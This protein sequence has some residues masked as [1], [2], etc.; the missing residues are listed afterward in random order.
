MLWYAAPLLSREQSL[1]LPSR[2]RYMLVLMTAMPLLLAVLHLLAMWPLLIAATMLCALRFRFGRRA[3]LE[4]NPWDGLAIAIVFVTASA[5]IPRAPTDGDSLAYHL[6]NAIAWVQAGSLDPTWMRYW[7][8]PGGSEISIAGLIATGGL[9]ITGVPSLLAAM[10]LTSR[11]S[12]WLRSL[13]VPAMTATAMSAAFITIT[14]VAFQTYDQRNDLVLAA[15]F[16][17][18]LWMLRNDAWSGALPIAMLALIKPYGWVYALSAIV[19]TRKPRALVGFVPLALWV[20]HDALLA[21]RAL[22]SI[23]STNAIGTWSTTIAGN[24]PASLIVLA[25]SIAERG[26]A[27][28]CCFVA[29]VFALFARGKERS[30]AIAGTCALVLFLFT[31]FGYANDMPQLALGWSLRYDLP[32]LALGVLCL[33][34][35][36][37]RFPIPIA[38]L[39]ACSALAGIARLLYI[40]NHDTSILIAFLVAVVAGLAAIV[41]FLA[42]LR[43]VAGFAATAIALVLMLYGS[44]VAAAHVADFYA[45]STNETAFFRWF[46][47]H[48]HDAES[49]NLRAGELLMLAPS[50]RVYDAD[51]VLCSR[52]SAESA[53][54]VVANNAAAAQTAK[55]CGE[56]LFEDADFI[57]VMPR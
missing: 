57:A 23:A 5:F 52:A 33:A 1:D 2:L 30:I 55:G 26:P 16:V 45:V 32:S 19:C 7:W 40:L 36:G 9:W 3:T 18:S 20:V 35:L 29:P 24:V 41:A 56:V 12:M 51:S 4:Y 54:I 49:V 42:P 53:L 6:P 8:Y 31:P 27:A 48:G 38:V 28:V 13:D 43:R 44:S 50:A 21:P 47:S 39:A 11:I 37:R 10:M 22:I 15:W 34:S 46:E 14:T 25:K 17:E